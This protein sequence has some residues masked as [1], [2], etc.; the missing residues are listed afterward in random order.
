[1]KIKVIY[2]SVY[3]RDVYRPNCELSQT[4]VDLLEQKTLT[5][6]NLRLLKTR[7]WDVEV[8]KEEST[9]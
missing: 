6:D 4:L 5:I 9:I 3:G 7:G 1:M 8:C 2:K